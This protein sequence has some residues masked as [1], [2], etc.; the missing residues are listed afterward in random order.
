[1]TQKKVFKGVI[2]GRNFDSVQEYNKEMTRLLNLGENIDAHSSTQVVNE[3]EAKEEVKPQVRLLYGFDNNLHYIDS[4]VDSDINA[5]KTRIDGVCDQLN[6]LY[7]EVLSPINKF[8]SAAADVYR[9]QVEEILKTLDEDKE[10]TITAIKKYQDKLNVLKDSKEIIDLYNDYY[11]SIHEE[12]TGDLET[13]CDETCCEETCCGK[14]T[15]TDEVSDATRALALI[16]KIL[17]L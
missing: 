14:S 10:R 8:D 2:N 13:C 16:Q 15:K 4:V 1:M 7:P 11:S 12:L 9:T 5:N 17:G 6:N 3:E